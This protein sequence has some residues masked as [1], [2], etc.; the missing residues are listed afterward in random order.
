[1]NIRPDEPLRRD[2]IPPV[3]PFLVAA[4]V[5][6]LL[7]L[8][9]VTARGT[10]PEA[11]QPSRRRPS[12]PIPPPSAIESFTVPIDRSAWAEPLRVTAVWQKPDGETSVYG[13]N[14]RFASS[15]LGPGDSVSTEVDVPFL[16][17]MNNPFVNASCGTGRWN[18]AFDE[19]GECPA[20]CLRVFRPEQRRYVCN[21]ATFPLV[22]EV[23]QYTSNAAE[24]FMA[25]G[26]RR[27]MLI[28]V[29]SKAT[30]RLMLEPWPMDLSFTGDDLRLPNL[31]PTIRKRP[32]IGGTQ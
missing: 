13:D 27:R 5:F 10:C 8:W 7:M 9:G 30:G 16:R 17:D 28:S 24:A 22:V 11:S 12:V 25:V 1:M 26:Q 6:V 18:N 4:L 23:P 15:A 2:P 19:T 32:S 21:C 20:S 3:N 14:E 29:R 31:S